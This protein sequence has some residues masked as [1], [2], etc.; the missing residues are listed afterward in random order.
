M[1]ASSLQSICPRTSSLVVTFND[2]DVHQLE[3]T[4]YTDVICMSGT[5]LALKIN[6]NTRINRNL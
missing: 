1:L 5:Q 3:F 2:D 4:T 6:R